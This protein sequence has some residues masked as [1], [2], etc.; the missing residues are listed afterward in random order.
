MVRAN[1]FWLRRFP[2]A[3]LGGEEQGGRQTDERGETIAAQRRVL[4]FTSTAG[5]FTTFRYFS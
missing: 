1:D 5:P 3:W 2:A 4:A